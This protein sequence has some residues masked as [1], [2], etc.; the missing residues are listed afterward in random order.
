MNSPTLIF[1]PNSLSSSIFYTKETD[2]GGSWFGQEYINIIN[3]RYPNRIFNNCYEWC[4]GPGFI[5][6]S[7][8]ANNLCSNLWLTDIHY[9]AIQ[10]AK[11]TATYPKNNWNN[12]VSVYLLEDLALLPTTAMFDL[13]VS[14]PPHF[15]DVVS[16]DDSNKNRI[17]TDV[18]WAAHKNFFANI[19]SHL[20][21]D[22]IILLQENMLGST[23]ES[24]RPFI[25]SAGLKITDWFK[26]DIWFKEDSRPQIYYI[27][28]M[29]NE[30]ILR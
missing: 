2:G 27:E 14:N 29:H 6:Y 17:C 12:N 3:N 30:N 10:L 16:G 5:G 15:V 22:G 4:S 23:I 24:F 21:P 26:S 13:I 20:A 25:E 7:I 28:I 11:E 19:K 8:L 18:D 9:P 1:T